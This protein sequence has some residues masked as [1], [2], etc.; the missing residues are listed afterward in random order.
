LWCE[1]FCQYYT[2]TPQNCQAQS[3]PFCN[4]SVSGD[5]PQP[6]RARAQAR[7]RWLRPLPDVV[8]CQARRPG[9]TQ[10][11]RSRSLTLC[12]GEQYRARIDAWHF[13]RP[14]RSQKG[15]RKASRRDGKSDVFALSAHSLRCYFSACRHV[16]IAQE[17]C[18]PGK[19]TVLVRPNGSRCPQAT[20]ALDCGQGGTGWQPVPPRVSEPLRYFV[21][22]QVSGHE[23]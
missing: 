16:R 6:A 8:L 23:P 10:P 21:I 3:V 17:S 1:R 18:L 13:P 7:E 11:A 4:R 12:A 2:I 22:H 15:E 19:T 9:R 5:S 20:G 14:G